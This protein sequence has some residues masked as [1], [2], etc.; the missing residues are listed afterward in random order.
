MALSKDQDKL[1]KQVCDNGNIKQ[2]EF[3]KVNKI[4]KNRNDKQ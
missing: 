4:V 3:K 2:P 1:E